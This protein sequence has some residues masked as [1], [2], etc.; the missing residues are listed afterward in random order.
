MIHFH[1]IKLIYNP[2]F[3]CALDIVADHQ[4]TEADL[5]VA[6]LMD[7]IEFKQVFCV[8]TKSQ[9]LVLNDLLKKLSGC[10]ISHID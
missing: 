5:L 1:I 2:P 6:L 10:L 9:D 3:I 8:A 4:S 7:G